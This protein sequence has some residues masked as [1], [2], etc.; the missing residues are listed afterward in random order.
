MLDAAGRYGLAGRPLRLCLGD[1]GKLRLPAVLHWRLNHFVVLA[2]VGRR[3]LLIHDP[4]S[5]R[6]RVSWKE[7]DEAFTGVAVE[8]SVV[9]QYRR[10]PRK[11]RLGILEIAGNIGRLWRYLAAA[12][13]LLLII[14]FLALVPAVA[15]QVLIDEVVLG[16]DKSWLYGA[17]GGL[18]AVML[19]TVLLDGLQKWIGLYTGT[20]LAM[21]SSSNLVTH[22]YSLP[23]PF[24]E[25]R[26]LGD[27]LSKLGSLGP[28]RQALTEDG[29]AVVVH[30]I[31]LATTLIVMLNYSAALTL[32]SVAGMLATTTL[33]LVLVA[34]SRRVGEEI[35]LQRAAE[36]SSLLETLRGFS[37]VHSLGIADVRRLH[38]QEAFLRAT[39]A[40]VRQ[41]KLGILRSSVAG[42]I[43]VVEQIAF[44]A[45]GVGGIVDRDISV[46]ILFAF[47]SLRGRFAGAAA[48]LSGALQQLVL[49]KVHTRRLSDLALATAERPGI[50][51]AVS[52]PLTGSLRA[53]DLTFAYP[54]GRD[55]I[56]GFSL[57][58]AAGAH[59]VITGP[60][61]C[62]KSTL[63]KLLAN[64]LEPRSGSVLYDGIEGALR[65]RD[66]LRRQV[67]IVQQ[68]DHLFQ[69]SIASNISAFASAPDLARVRAAAVLAEIWQ[70]IQR[71]PMRLETPLGDTAQC[72]SGGQVQRLLLARALYRKPRILFLD[73]ATSH[74]DPDL[75]EAV[76][77]N[78]DRLNLT[79]V[80]VAHRPAAIRLAERVIRLRGV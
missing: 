23:V 34:P 5:G 26:H 51:G 17:L 74:L 38:W 9:R 42:V 4:A 15:T 36:N 70:D 47:L 10:R 48:G 6:K 14:Q 18:A 46:G 30:L 71:L 29:I 13:L 35:L 31:V 77:R 61:G 40:T 28:V 41:G 62:G 59:V 52:K 39:D 73:E 21:D 72:L 78:I 76:L 20:R 60:S 56:S 65:D 45:I 11:D 68:N 16:L 27:L 67:G 8:F 63:L 22:L 69:G 3:H 32:V 43:N 66:A 44:L 55:V 37:T 54:D 50:R 25:N 79:V 2:R 64:Q 33:F 53:A 58:I 80:S 57:A 1:V 75:E 12:L 49:L 24:V 19:V 7:F